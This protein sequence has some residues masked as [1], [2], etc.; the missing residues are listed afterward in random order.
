MN[1]MDLFIKIGV[2]DQASGKMGEISSGMI[3]KGQLIADAISSAVGFA[4]EKLIAFGKQAIDSYAD[5][6]QLIGGVETLFKESSDIVIT[7]A[8]QAYKTAGLSVNE[9]METVTSFSA[10]LLQ[11]T[12]RGAQTNLEMLEASLEAEYEAAK[13]AYDE[14]YDAQK[15]AL[16]AEYELLQKS[17]DEQYNAQKEAYDAEYKAL[18]DAQAA[19]IKAYTE[20]AD[21]VIASIDKDNKEL[22]AL[23]KQEKKDTLA[24]MKEGHKNE[25]EEL[26]THQSAS[27]KLLKEGGKQALAEQK[28]NNA[29]SLKELKESIS[30][31]LTAQKAGIADAVNAAE[32]ANMVSVTTLESQERAAELADMA[33]RDMSDNANKMGTSMAMIQNAYQ[34]FAKN[35]YTM[36]DNLKLGYGGT[37]EEMERLVA[38][39]AKLTD[40][41][42]AQSLAFDNVVLAIHAVQENLGI[43]G[44]TAKEAGAT[45]AGSIASMKS[46]YENLITGIGNENADIGKLFDDLVVSIVGDGSESNKG[47]LGNLLPRIEQV[48]KGIG[49][50]ADVARP[51]IEEGAVKVLDYFGVKMAD[52]EQINASLFEGANGIVSGLATLLTQ[53]DALD[54]LSEG[55]VGIL[56]GLTEKLTDSDSLEILGKGAADII[57]ELGGFIATTAPGIISGATNILTELMNGFFT[58]DNLNAFSEGAASIIET[59]GK[60][61]EEHSGEIATGAGKL[62]E[63]ISGVLKGFDWANVGY[64]IGDTVVSAI[65]SALESTLTAVGSLIGSVG[66][67]GLLG[68]YEALG[69]EPPQE[70]VDEYNEMSDFV[71]N[72]PGL[73]L[74]EG[75]GK[76]LGVIEEGGTYRPSY[77]TGVRWGQ[78]ATVAD[79]INVYKDL[80]PDLYSQYL[81][82]T[83][84]GT[85]GFDASG[86]MEAVQ[87]NINIDGET[88]A[89]ALYDPLTGLI[90]QKGAGPLR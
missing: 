29:D 62:A 26:K 82:N 78:N 77:T 54:K 9:Y 15:E 14:Q 55:A 18:K 79:R 42:D 20:Q 3:A 35:N 47:A 84:S 41:V 66:T 5:Y 31:M 64:T 23:K 76:G 33:I 16:D 70:L 43:T 68:I 53:T 80:Y 32:D 12:G 89:S 38:D 69:I 56:T 67:G 61:I 13:D 63:A 8:E 60:E 39:A 21:A 2:D 72:S 90:Q 51:Y 45:I 7:N 34:G 30:D 88:A 10:S 58:E 27:L 73:Q 85:V 22:I 1:L 25:L 81:Y 36:L 28:K 48:F 83:D 52:G 4:S 11:A 86:F 57:T 74:L 17:L 65:G 75:I 49:T 19:E 46:A 37:M 44:T 50:V 24:A 40:T 71:E 87:I 59:L 6:E